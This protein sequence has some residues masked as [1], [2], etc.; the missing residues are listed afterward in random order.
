MESLGEGVGDLYLGEDRLGGYY[1]EGLVMYD[2][3]GND[4]VCWGGE[5]V[6]LDGLRG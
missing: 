1:G 4:S 5:S 3:E 2:V 6:S